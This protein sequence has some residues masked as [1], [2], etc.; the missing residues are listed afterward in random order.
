MSNQTQGVDQNATA[1]GLSYKRWT[2]NDLIVVLNH[3]NSYWGQ[4]LP[5]NVLMT[6]VNY[7][8]EQHG[9]TAQDRIDILDAHRKGLALPPAKR[10]IYQD[11]DGI[12]KPSGTNV[13]QGCAQADGHLPPH[14]RI[15]REHERSKE[16][17]INKSD[18]TIS[19]PDSSEN[20]IS[21]VDKC[22]STC[23]VCY[24]DLAEPDLAHK[25]TTTCE[26]RANVC[27]ACLAKHIALELNSKTWDEILC[28][29]CN[30]HLIY[31]DIKQFADLQVFERSA[32]CLLF[33]SDTS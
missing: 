5:K 4:N 29:H 18:A 15:I 26:H 31:D 33:T 25:P 20:T 14:H 27:R 23:L 32:F 9:L 8:A 30:E 22:S 12:D 6:R 13:E 7:L 24:E 17:S 28:P 3:Y 2:I 1:L 10:A 21:E 19:A 11:I 16:A